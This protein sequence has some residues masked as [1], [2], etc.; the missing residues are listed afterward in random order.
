VSVGYTLHAFVERITVSR[1][2]MQF[3]NHDRQRISLR[4][5][6][7]VMQLERAPDRDSFKN[8]AEH[9]KYLI[10]IPER[11]TVARAYMQFHNHDRQCISLREIQNVMQLERAPDRGSLK[12]SN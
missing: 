9:N 1:A 12:S 2:H 8:A 11:I 5:I 6:Q 4:E 7:N 3:H 10:F